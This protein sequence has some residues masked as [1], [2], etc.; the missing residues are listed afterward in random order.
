MNEEDRW[1]SEV[2]TNVLN[3]REILYKY[4]RVEIEKK[5]RKFTIDTLIILSNINVK[6]VE[7]EV[8]GKHTE[9]RIERNV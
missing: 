6:V 1:S 7:Y 8:F 2:L 4:F 9:P 5:I 3:S